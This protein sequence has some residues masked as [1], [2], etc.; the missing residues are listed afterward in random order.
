MV[1]YTPLAARTR[2]AARKARIKL[3]LAAALCWLQVA[4]TKPSRKAAAGVL[5]E[6]QHPGAVSH[7][8][9][10]CERWGMRLKEEVNVNSH[11][12]KGPKP[13]ASDKAVLG[14]GRLLRRAAQR[15]KDHRGY[16]SVRHAVSHSK[17]AAAIVAA[18]HVGP[19][20]L[21]RTHCAMVLTGSQAYFLAQK[22]SGSS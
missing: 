9:D 1:K 15:N 21:V 4:D 19:F 3:R 16:S 2:G 5:F 7:P 11:F 17:Q 14:M 22:S 10:F 18:F 20:L 8:A 12:S 13:A 6:A